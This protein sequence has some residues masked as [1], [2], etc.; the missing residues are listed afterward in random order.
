MGRAR[1][2]GAPKPKV[3]RAL[4][5]TIREK[6]LTAYSAAKK[7]GVSV[8]AVQRFLNEERGL[9]LATVDKLADSLGLTL[10]PDDSGAEEAN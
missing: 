2:S 5:E 4:R 1:K 10:C 6:G 9:S 3:S 8:D 7:S